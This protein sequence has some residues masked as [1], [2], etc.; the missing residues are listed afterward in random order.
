MLAG[1]VQIKKVSAEQGITFANEGDFLVE[2]ST[3]L[4]LLD[5]LL[6]KLKKEGKRILIFSHFKIM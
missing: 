2:P 6:P 1:C 5:K 3:K 4:K